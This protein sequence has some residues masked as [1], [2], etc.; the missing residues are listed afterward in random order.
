MLFCTAGRRAGTGQWDT[1]TS[2]KCSFQSKEKMIP[3]ILPD[4]LVR[5]SERDIKR[6]IDQLF[7]LELEKY[8]FYYNYSK[9]FTAPREENCPNVNKV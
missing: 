2:A 9:F 7:L 6:Y 4:P 1:Y 8:V 5:K 3:L